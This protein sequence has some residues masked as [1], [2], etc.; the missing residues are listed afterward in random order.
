MYIK[1]CRIEQFI[2]E[3]NYELVPPNSTI[4]KLTTK[5]DVLIRVTYK[6]KPRIK[7]LEETFPIKDFLIKSA[8]AA[9]VRLSAKEAKSVRFESAKKR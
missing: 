9:G 3:K 7:V 4:F 2:L 1:R 5:E 6:P 8:R